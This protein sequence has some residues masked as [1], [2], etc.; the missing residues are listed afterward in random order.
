MP[1]YT[2]AIE[3]LDCY[4]ERDGQADV[5]SQRH[6]VKPFPLSSHERTFKELARIPFEI[7]GSCA[8]PPP[9]TSPCL[10]PL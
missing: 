3:R 4:P 10:S 7:D 9:E 6:E 1:A 2:W 8:P 5:A